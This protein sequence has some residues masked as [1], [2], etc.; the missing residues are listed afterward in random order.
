MRL[1]FN[2]TQ[3]L[4]ALTLGGM[5]IWLWSDRIDGMLYHFSQQQKASLGDV[6]HL[7]PKQYAQ[8]TGQYVSLKGVLGAKAANMSGLHPG[9]LHMRSVQIRQLLGSPVFVEF[10]PQQKS[11]KQQA[12]SQITVE[13]RL[14][15]LTAQGR[16]KKL[17]HFFQHN[18]ATNMPQQAYLLITHEHPGK[19]WHYPL[20]FMAS[21]IICAYSFLRAF[22][23]RPPHKNLIIST[24]RLDGSQSRLF[25]PCGCFV[26]ILL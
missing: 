10:D 13:G 15:Q 21:L 23:N 9:C 8:A 11:G 24:Q 3:L 16:L 1:P 2:I 12:F 22:R 6:L 25:R 7:Q 17:W 4:I 19:M 20:F 26:M 18:F 5:V 14:V